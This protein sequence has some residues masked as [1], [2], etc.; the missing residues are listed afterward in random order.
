[1]EF[2]KETDD[3]I[4]VWSDGDIVGAV[5]D[6]P[7]EYIHE[8][9]EVMALI[10]KYHFQSSGLP[11]ENFSFIANSSLSG[12]SHPCSAPECRKQKLDQLASFAALYADEVYIQNPFESILLR[13]GQAIREVERHEVLAGIQNYLYLRPLIEKGLI[14]YATTNFNFCEQHSNE[15][16]KPLAESIR[17]KEDKLIHTLE[18]HLKGS[19]RVTFDFTE[20]NKAKPFLKITGPED[21]IA[22][23]GVYL[24]S[25]EPISEMFTPFMKEKSPYIL[26]QDEIEGSRVLD[27][28][29]GPIV[30]D[31]STQEWHS[32]LNGTSYL[33]DNKTQMEVAS[34]INSKVYAANSDV[35]EKSLKHYLP[36]I[37]SKDPS[38]IMELRLREEEAFAVYRDKLNKFMQE[39]S[40]WGGVEVSKI[41]R[42]QLLPEINLIEKKVKDWKSNARAGIT[43]KLLFGTATASIG[44]YEGMLPANIGE[45]VTAIGGVSAVAGTLME[46]NK[47]LKE[48][49]EARKNDFYFL[50]QAS[51]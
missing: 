24:H 30:N 20:G 25:Y 36:A 21:V 12:G 15:V 23:G 42:D 11:N 28:I 38:A 8:F 46:Y 47:T 35:F 33:C 32:A 40:S 10:S 4:S 43:E 48:K 17:K 27:Q 22:H 49:Q 26:S 39:S 34:K 44:L 51:Q 1:M 9:L 31:L 7:E 6:S 5:F 41:F 16:G 3:A 45:I 14:K 19:C 18:E 29:I 50:W 13:G 37:Y 2:I